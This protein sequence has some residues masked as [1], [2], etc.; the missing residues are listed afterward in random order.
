MKEI[1]AAKAR[2]LLEQGRITGFVALRQDGPNLGPHIFTDPADL[3]ALSLGDK[4]RPGDARYSVIG[5]LT[6]LAGLFPQETFGV[7]VRGCDERALEIIMH[8]TRLAALAPERVIRVGFSCPAELAQAHHCHKPWPDA[9]TAGER[10]PGVTAGEEPAADLLTELEEWFPVLDRC[11]KCFGCRNVCPACDC[12]EC[13]METEALV[14]QRELPPDPSFLLTR[15]VHMADRCVYCG[16]CEEVCP[17]RIPLQSLYRFAARTLGL[18]LTLPGVRLP[19]RPVDLFRR[20][21]LI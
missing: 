12:R 9:L 6:R 18:G 8:E 13:T 2:E 4:D 21:R 16:L 1:I 10:T 17:A 14:P 20:P 5:L 3:D 7:L 19:L 11:L 15:A